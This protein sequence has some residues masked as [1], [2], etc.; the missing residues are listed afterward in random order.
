MKAYLDECIQK[1]E[2]PHI[3]VNFCSIGEEGLNSAYA[4]YKA[5]T[6]SSLEYFDA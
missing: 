5:V 4:N 2:T 3:L 6:E 1:N